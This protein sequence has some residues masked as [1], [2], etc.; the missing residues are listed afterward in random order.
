[1][2]GSRSGM[3]MKAWHGAHQAARQA[4][5]WVGLGLAL[6]LGAC[7]GGGSGTTTTDPIPPPV[8]SVGTVSGRVLAADTGAG[9]AGVK[10]KAGSVSA[11]SA[12]D[13]A[14]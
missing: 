9:I 14:I 13:G 3:A 8:A 2:T 10:V 5:A 1:M 7:G 6:T 12:A 4:A 11:D